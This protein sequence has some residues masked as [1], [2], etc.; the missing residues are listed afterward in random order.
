M[1]EQFDFVEAFSAET[2]QQ[3]IN[4]HVEQQPLKGTRGERDFEPVCKI[5]LPGRAATWLA[6]E[7]D[8]D[9][10]IAFGLA[11]MGFGQPELGYFD[12]NEIYDTLGLGGLRME[13]D[14]YFKA[15]HPISWYAEDARKHGRIRA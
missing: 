13:I 9:D 5:F 8:P 15:E 3:L 12:L 11:D 10:G 2:L 14:R 6:T 1:S 4:N 7:L